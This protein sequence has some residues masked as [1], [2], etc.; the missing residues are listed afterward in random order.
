MLLEMERDNLTDALTD[1]KTDGV[2]NHDQALPTL[3]KDLLVGTLASESVMNSLTDLVQM[4]QGESWA[5]TLTYSILDIPP[6]IL[7]IPVC[8]TKIFRSFPQKPQDM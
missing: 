3:Y 8:P 4:L 1:W 7:T 2:S 6:L 5:N